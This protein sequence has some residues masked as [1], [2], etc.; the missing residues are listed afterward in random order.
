MKISATAGSLP[1]RSRWRPLCRMPGG[2]G[3]SWNSDR[4]P[5]HS[6]RQTDDCSG[7]ARSRGRPG[8]AGRCRGS[9]RG[10]SGGLEPGGADRRLPA[11]DNIEIQSDGTVCRVAADARA[12]NRR[13]SRRK[14]CRRAQVRR[15][16]GRVELARAEAST[17]LMRPAFAASTEGTR[18]YLSGVPYDDHEGADRGRDRGHRLVRTRVPGA[19]GLS[20]D[21][22]L[23][24][25]N[26]AI[27][28]CDKL[29][30]DQSVERVVLRRRA[31]CSRSKRRRLSSRPTDRRRLPG[32]LADPPGPSGNHVIVERAGLM[33]SI[34]R[35]AA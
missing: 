6:R 12:S 33:R 22:T 29:L 16:T 14:I 28:I 27:K 13:L 10:G 35:I 8:R 4:A 20:S 19:T 25:P 26:V 32:L 3:I 15:R 11:R 18:D 30:A 24:V 34:D 5:Y 2:S 21:R 17:L 7:C 9:R 23:I 1:A 31:P